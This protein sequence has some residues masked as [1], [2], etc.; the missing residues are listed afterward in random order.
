MKDFLDR[1]LAKL[2]P[3]RRLKVEQDAQRIIAAHILAQ[4]RESGGMSQVQ[5]AERLDVRQATVSQI[6]NQGDCKISTLVKY[7][8]ALGGKIQLKV[9]MPGHRAVELLEAHPG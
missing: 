7:V 4:L 5:L 8:N 6:E 9:Q 2:S 1:E 3:E